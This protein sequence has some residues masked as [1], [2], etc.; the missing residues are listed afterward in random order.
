MLEQLTIL[1]PGLIGGSVARAARARGA[2][3]AGSSSGRGGPRRGSPCAEQ[4][5]C[6]ATS[7]TPEEAVKDADMVVIAAPVDRIVPLLRQV[8][9]A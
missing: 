9:P 7:E 8:A 6:S 2:W 3:P 1:A 5:W 4:P